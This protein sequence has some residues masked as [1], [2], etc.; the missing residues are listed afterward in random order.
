[1]MI[2]LASVTAVIKGAGGC[3]LIASLKIDP[4]AAL[5]TD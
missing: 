5:R 2:T 4:I 1:M 3:Q